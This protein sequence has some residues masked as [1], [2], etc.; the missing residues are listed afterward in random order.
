MSFQEVIE[1]VSRFPVDCGINEAG[2][3]R[4]NIHQ[5]DPIDVRRG[6]IVVQSEDGF[7]VFTEGEVLPI[8]AFSLAWQVGSQASG[9]DPILV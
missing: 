4:G 2:G 6:H 5:S 1:I 9:F 3:M 8:F 7:A